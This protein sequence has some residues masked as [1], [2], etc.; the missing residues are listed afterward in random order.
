MS[1]MPVEPRL[2]RCLLQSTH[3]QCELE[4]AMI[5]AM[6]SVE[7]PYVISRGIDLS[8]L[9]LHSHGS[10]SSSSASESSGGSGNSL[11]ER[12]QRLLECMGTFRAPEGDHLTL[13]NIFKTFTTQMQQSQSWCDSMCLQHRVLTKAAEIYS[14]LCGLIRKYRGPFAEYLSKLQNASNSTAGELPRE[15]TSCYDDTE[16]ILRCVLSGYFSHVAQMQ[17]NGMYATTRGTPQSKT[18]KKLNNF[19]CA[20]IYF[21]HFNMLRSRPTSLYIRLLPLCKW[22]SRRMGGLP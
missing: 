20:C 16:C 3:T 11:E 12:K 1:E 2:A 7:F 15:L 8:T 10:S 18:R 6:C 17:P 9:N 4:M 22:S 5:A 13:L 21:L 19:L 14:H